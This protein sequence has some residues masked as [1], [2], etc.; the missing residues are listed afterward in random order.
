[1]YDK[2]VSIFEF[3]AAGVNVK[4][5]DHFDGIGGFCRVASFGVQ[6]GV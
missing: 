3:R 6:H 4:I 1:M 5:G 2:D